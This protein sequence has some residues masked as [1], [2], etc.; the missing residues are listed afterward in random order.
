[1]AKSPPKKKL[2]P[3]DRPKTVQ[4]K[5]LK[6][7]VDGKEQI[8]MAS[9]NIRKLAE[10]LELAR[11]ESVKFRDLLSGLTRIGQSFQNA[12]SVLQ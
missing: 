10:E 5:G 4:R 1:M 7:A 3:W 6:L 9:T 2:L 8:V 11:T 12:M